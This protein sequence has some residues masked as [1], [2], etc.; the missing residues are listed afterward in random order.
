MPHKFNAGHRDHIPSERHG[1]SKRPR[2]LRV[3]LRGWCCSVDLMQRRLHQVSLLFPHLVAGGLALSYAWQLSQTAWRTSGMQFVSPLIVI[4]LIHTCWAAVRRDLRPGF[5]VML[6]RRASGTAGVLIGLL[7]FG[8]VFAPMPAQANEIGEIVG[9][10]AMVVICGLMIAGVI[11][12][13]ALALWLLIKVV[14]LVFGLGGDKGD[15]KSRLFDFGSMVACCAVL[16][17]A[18]LEGLPGGFAF[19]TAGQATSSHDIPAPP[20]QIWEVMQVATSPDFP[21]P[22]ILTGF[23]R[24]IAVTTDEGVVLGA[25]RVVQFAGRE[26]AGQLHLQVTERTESA[27]QFTVLS[28]TTPYAGWIGYKRLTYEIVPQG[29]GSRLSVTLEFERKLAPAW[30][31]AP[32]MRGAAYLAVDVLARDVQARTPGG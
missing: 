26:G 13:A 27:V 30:F 17:V 12:A 2:Q 8:S 15:P 9:T 18:S 11:C 16:G 3:V 25:D 19:E 1:V 5:A 20:A 32:V 6:L 21:L 29:T 31:F 24:P 7:F 23:P 22:G 4:I 10:L 14:S 28:D